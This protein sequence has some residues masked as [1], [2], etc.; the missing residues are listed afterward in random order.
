MFLIKKIASYLSLGL[1][2]GR[3]SSSR[4]LPPS[5]DPA[6]QNEYGSVRIRIRSIV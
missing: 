3:L 4:S 2:K 1:H 5:K 6:D